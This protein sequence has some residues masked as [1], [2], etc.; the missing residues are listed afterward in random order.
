MLG[1]VQRCKPEW[2]APNEVLYRGALAPISGDVRFRVELN[3]WEQDFLFREQI[4]PELVVAAGLDPLRA[5][6]VVMSEFF[7]APEPTEIAPRAGEGGPDLRF[8]AMTVGEGIAFGLEA[9]A[10][11][12][13]VPIR[14]SW[15][16][17]VAAN[18]C[19]KQWTTLHW[20]RC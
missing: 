20:G 12:V 18:S 11:G 10:T 19:W 4:P 5:R 15:E 16:R 2:T 13:R 3:L 14:K 9:G 17:L 8:G 6:V 7:E 1:E